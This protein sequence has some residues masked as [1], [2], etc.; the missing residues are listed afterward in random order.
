MEFTGKWVWD[1]SSELCST[2]FGAWAFLSPYGHLRRVSNLEEG[3]SVQLRT[4]PSKGSHWQLG[5]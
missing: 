5:K 1:G 2:E 3:R 4:I